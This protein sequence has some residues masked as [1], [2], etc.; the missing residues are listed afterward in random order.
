MNILNKASFATLEH[1]TIDQ[2]FPL[3]CS[4]SHRHEIIWQQRKSYE[5]IWRIFHCARTIVEDW[6]C[7]FAEMGKSD[8]FFLQ[9]QD[10]YDNW[11]YERMDPLIVEIAPPNIL[12]LE[13]GHHRSF[14]FGCILLQEKV[15]F[16][17]LPVLNTAKLQFN[18]ASDTSIRISYSADEFLQCSRL[19]IEDDPLGEIP[20]QMRLKNRKVYDQKIADAS[21]VWKNLSKQPTGLS[22]PPVR[23]KLLVRDNDLRFD[24]VIIEPDD[25]EIAL[26]AAFLADAGANNIQAGNISFFSTEQMPNQ[27]TTLSPF[28]PIIEIQPPYY[29]LENAKGGY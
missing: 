21:L 14:V 1:I 7:D 17:P 11:D 8:E 9:C 28:S 3:I 22:I 20:S 27:R 29:I 26:A 2:F 4:D 16:R 23:A 15:Q 6:N 13:N 12:R 18:T 25:H 19:A 5:I 24:A 10:M